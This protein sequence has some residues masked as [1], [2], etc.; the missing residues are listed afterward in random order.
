MT[1]QTIMIKIAIVLAALL[2]TTAGN[3]QSGL[4]PQIIGMASMSTDGTVT[5]HLTRTGDGQ[6]ANATFIYKLNDAK[7]DEILNHVGG[8]KP[9]E[10]KPVTPWPD[11]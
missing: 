9:G 7:Y 2:W 6:Y 3:A 8:L 1:D 11:N 4:T 5:V 10:T